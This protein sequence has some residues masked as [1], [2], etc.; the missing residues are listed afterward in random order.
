[1]FSPN[2]K[3]RVVERHIEDAIIAL[4]TELVKFEKYMRTHEIPENLIQIIS[5][6][7][8]LNLVSSYFIG[9]VCGFDLEADEGMK[10]IIALFKSLDQVVDQHGA[11]VLEKLEQQ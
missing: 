8:M 9:R 10:E 11:K 5:M 4:G 6:R 7:A 3:Q 1:M 2:D